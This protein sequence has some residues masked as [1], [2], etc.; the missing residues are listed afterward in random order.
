MKKLILLLIFVLV[1]SMGHS[2]LAQTAQE[3]QQ[4]KLIEREVSRLESELKSFQRQLD[5]Q[6]KLEVYKLQ[7]ELREAEKLADTRRNKELESVAWANQ[8][9][10]S[11][12][13]EID[14]IE[15]INTNLDIEYK[16]EEIFNIRQKKE[17]MIERWTSPEYNI[18][19]EMSCVT[20]RRRERSNVIRRQELVLS[21]I[22]GNLN[23]TVNPGVSEGGYKVIFD[24]K[25]SLNTTFI[26]LG[27]DGGQR[28]AVS[29]AGKTKERHYIL[30]GRYVVE[31]YVAG[32]KMNEVGRLTIDGEAHFYETEPCFGFV[33]KARY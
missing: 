1:A 6:K 20:K 23:S 2:V 5:K 25:Y 32:R 17:E 28:L 11:L 9:K 7:R 12:L 19:R 26:L 22:E 16:L 31:Y 33:Y 4:M 21:K 13:L 30:P 15:S 8:V 24:N 10:D 27:V 18:P 14:S 3:K 29:L